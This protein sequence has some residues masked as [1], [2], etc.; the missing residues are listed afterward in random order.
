MAAGDSEV[1]DLYH[2]IRLT[3][4]P[5]AFSEFEI[6]FVDDQETKTHDPVTVTLITG[7]T[8]VENNWPFLLVSCNVGTGRIGQV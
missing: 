7:M 5:D 6:S 4:I 3:V 8:Y 2:G 1:F